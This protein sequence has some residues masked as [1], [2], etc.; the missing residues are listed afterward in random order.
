MPTAA[1]LDRFDPFDGALGFP[2]ATRVGSLVFVSGLT[3][4]RTDLTVPETFGEQAELV[5]D[6][7]AG[8][9]AHYGAGLEHVISQMIHVTVDPERAFVELGPIRQA[10]FGAGNPSSTLVQVGGLVDPRYLI[11]ITVTAVVGAA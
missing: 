2:L 6:H 9:L 10:R 8:V 3:A 11:E 7:I 4:L 5:Y 1:P